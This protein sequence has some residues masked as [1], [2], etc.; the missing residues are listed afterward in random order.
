METD[1][2][3]YLIDATHAPAARSW[4]HS[5]NVDGCEFPI[6]NLPF[7]VFTADAVSTAIGVGIGDRVLNLRAAA[8]AGLLN[9]DP[10]VS[11]AAVASNLNLLMSLD[12]GRSNS[13]RHALFKLLLADSPGRDIVA[14]AVPP[15][16]RPIDEV[17]FHLPCRIGG[18]TDFLTS[19]HHTERHGR[20]KGLKDPLPPAFM[21]LPI[22]YNGRVSSMRVSGTDVV[23]PHGQFKDAAGRVVYGPAVAMD[24]ELEMGAFVRKGNELTRPVPV[25]DAS[26]HLFGLSLFNDWSAK[27]IQWWEQVLGPF[28]GKSF[29]TSLS[30]WIVTME[31]LAPFRVSAA[32]RAADDPELLPHLR[33]ASDQQAGAFDIEMEAWISSNGMRDSGQAETRLTLTNL[34]NLYWTFAQ[35][36]SHHT[37]NGCNL[38]AGDFLGSGTASGAEPG[39]EGCLT[40]IT[41]AGTRPVRISAS[42]EERR[43][44]EDGDEIIFRACARRPGFVPIGFG[45][46]RGRLL[47]AQSDRA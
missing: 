21:S 5:A 15:M 41:S 23:R 9:V 47:P 35:M 4:I 27:D 2:M 7:C 8:E 37:S 46:C 25:E 40:E 20:F 28:L 34:R 33:A 42:G 16:L 43:W 1:K 10:A 38:E 31:A 45:E 30:P 19:R 26:G 3:T 32:S 44:L 11:R 14:S 39:S 6:Q 13:L 18:Y 36:L 17:V 12:E 29:M 24:F 22:A